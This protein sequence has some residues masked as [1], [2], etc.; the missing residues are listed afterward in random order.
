MLLKA[1]LREKNV[2]LFDRA[3]GRS[4]GIEKSVRLARE[5]LELSEEQLGVLRAGVAAR[6]TAFRVDLI[7]LKTSA[8]LGGVEAGLRSRLG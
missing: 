2:K 3:S 8:T 5:H 7:W 6:T 4:V 1:A